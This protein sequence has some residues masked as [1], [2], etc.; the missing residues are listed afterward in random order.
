MKASAS[1]ASLVFVAC[2]ISLSE[3]RIALVYEDSAFVHSLRARLAADP[4]SNWSLVELS[5]SVHLVDVE[6]VVGDVPAAL[7]DAM[8]KLKLWQSVGYVTP[9]EYRRA[10]N[11][12]TRYPGV[13]VCRG[14]ST[15]GSEYARTIAE[16]IVAASL[17]LVFKL[18]ATSQQML[19][20]AWEQGSP[21]C[22]HHSTFGTRPALAN[23][24]LGIVG[25]GKV[26]AQVAALSSN[27]FGSVVASNPNVTGTAPAPLAWCVCLLNGPSSLLRVSTQ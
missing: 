16:W 15:I 13:Q 23:M 1:Q 3:S 21:S 24:T 27:L 10:P 12:T 8:P 4:Q 11:I 20:C 14:G 18:G 6:A 22:P 9:V 2:L 25:Y 26:G 5:D 19:D 7:L 17:E